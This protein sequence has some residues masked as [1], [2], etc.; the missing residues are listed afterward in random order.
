MKY[1]VYTSYQNEQCEK[2]Y[3]LINWILRLIHVQKQLN[4]SFIISYLVN[5]RRIH[6]WKHVISCL[7][8]CL[9]GKPCF[10]QLIIHEWIIHVWCLDQRENTD[11]PMKSYHS[12]GKQQF[13]PAFS[14]IPYY[15]G[16]F[17]LQSYSKS[18]VP[19]YLSVCVCVSKVLLFFNGAV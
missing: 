8:V 11:E 3:P 13:T 14:H 19:F 5:R 1:T 16:D 10:K 6:R 12:T 2:E 18:L 17:F 9:K 4:K 15:E 7:P